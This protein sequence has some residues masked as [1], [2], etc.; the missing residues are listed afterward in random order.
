MATLKVTETYDGRLPVYHVI[1]EVI[2]HSDTKDVI[3][4]SFDTYEEAE[5]YCSQLI[6][7]G[8]VEDSTTSCGEEDPCS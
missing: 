2:T 5:Q 4:K 3:I 1:K 6:T 7:E 8:R